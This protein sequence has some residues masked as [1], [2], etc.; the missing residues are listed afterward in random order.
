MCR[1]VIIYVS[2]RSVRNIVIASVFLLG[3]TCLL[4]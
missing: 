4:W 3:S 1:K 2:T